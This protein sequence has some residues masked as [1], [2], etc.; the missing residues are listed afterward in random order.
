MTDPGRTRL[1]GWRLCGLAFLCAMPALAD[2]IWLELGSAGAPALDHT[3]A[4]LTAANLA[5]YTAE[6]RN[7]ADQIITTADL[8]GL[9]EAA[10]GYFVGVIQLGELSGVTPITL[11]LSQV[12]PYAVATVGSGAP[13][14][15]DFLPTLDRATHGI[16]A[17]SLTWNVNG[18]P[19]ANPDSYTIAEDTELFVAAPGLLDNDVDTDPMTASLATAPATGTA[20]VAA[21]GSFTFSPPLNAAGEISF[22][23]AADDGNLSATS[24]VTITITPVNDPPQATADG[25]TTDEDTAVSD[26]V[27]ANDADPDEGDVLTVSVVTPATT[28]RPDAAPVR[29]VHLH[30]RGKRQWRGQLQLLGQRHRSCGLRNRYHHDHAGE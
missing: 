2:I 26:D 29:C 5:N 13:N 23:Y 8:S 18:P 22:I 24:T 27:L 12:T 1:R 14:A 17:A 9:D 15:D 7:G 30:T 4:L 19:T 16:T 21:D 3:D 25:Y 10:S 28:G 20:T 6:V 11:V